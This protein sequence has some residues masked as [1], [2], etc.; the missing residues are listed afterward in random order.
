M[1]KKEIRRE[2]K[3]QKLKKRYRLWRKGY[4]LKNKGIDPESLY[5]SYNLY[6]AFDKLSKTNDFNNLKS[7]NKQV[8]LIEQLAF[9][10]NSKDQDT[11]AELLEVLDINILNQSLSVLEN[12]NL[13]HTNRY[14]I[15][16]CKR[17]VEKLKLK[18]TKIAIIEKPADTRAI[19]T[20]IQPAAF[21]KEVNADIKNPREKPKTP[22]NIVVK[23]SEEATNNS[24]PS[25]IYTTTYDSDE[26]SA[27]SCPDE[28]LIQEMCHLIDKNILEI[29]NSST[30]DI[31]LFGR[32]QNRLNEMKEITSSTEQKAMEKYAEKTLITIEEV[33]NLTMRIQRLKAS[34]IKK[35]AKFK[36]NPQIE[37]VKSLLS[38][39]TIST[40]IL[41]GVQK[42]LLIITD[43]KFAYKEKLE[44]A[45]RNGQNEGNDILIIPDNNSTKKET[46]NGL[47]RKIKSFVKNNIKKEPAISS[48]TSVVGDHSDV[49]SLTQISNLSIAPHNREIAETAKETH[50]RVRSRQAGC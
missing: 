35:K 33:T 34:C 38:N 8:K 16:A 42:K 32:L 5:N 25:H 44:N 50:R 24:I 48:S 27:I 20:Q 11:I 9:S 46:S 1:A 22:N 13:Q 12:Y 4:S 3:L 28:K 21:N 40:E 2:N 36:N 17:K 47:W 39:Y 43:F 23:T 49:S 19:N 45:I 37:V 41:E 14:D 30:D 7:F 29:V 6:L 26:I 18:K 31:V 10:D 15:S